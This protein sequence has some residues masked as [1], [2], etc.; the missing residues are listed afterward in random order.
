MPRP[1]PDTPP[2]SLGWCLVLP[3]G[4]I[5]AMVSLAL[6][7]EDPAA[8]AE[9][10]Y[11]AL[12]TGIVLLAAAATAPT[13]SAEAGLGSL[14]VAAAVWTLPAGPARGAVALAFATATLAVA[15]ARWLPRR[16]PA[17]RDGED[18]RSGGAAGSSGS[19]ASARLP[20]VPVV[21]LALGLQALLRG[22]ELLAAGGGW[23]ASFR[24]VALAADVHACWSLPLRLPGGRVGGVLAVHHDT[25]RAPSDDELAIVRAA[26][27]LAELALG[28]DAE[29]AVLRQSERYARTMA[30]FRRSVM[31]LVELGL[32]QGEP[33]SFDQRLLEE[34]VRVIPGASTA[35]ILKR[36]HDG[37]FRF[38]AVFGFDLE[39]LRAVRIPPEAV[40]FGHASVDGRPFVVR[41]P[42]LHESL[43]PPDAATLEEECEYDALQTVLNVPIVVGGE[44]TAY[45]ALGNYDDADVFGEEEVEMARIF[46]GQV[47]SLMRRFELERSLYVQAYEDTLTGLPNRAAFKDH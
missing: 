26:A 9:T 36:A 42:R 10:G 19:T 33:D 27:G 25:P 44:M 46:G 23:A 11:L 18:G 6:T 30:D 45:L 22:E 16:V 20:V 15:A 32:D 1:R 31:S 2:R 13:P 5:L 34:A 28:H 39:R 4:A 35:A 3:V 14:L 24:A 43:D 37:A 7:Q 17:S 29:T 41:H 8:A 40:S 47:A 12:A 21:A 38:S